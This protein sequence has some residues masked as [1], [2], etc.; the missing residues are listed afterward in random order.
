MLVIAELLGLPAEGRGLFQAWQ[1]SRT[2]A[3][4]VPND[5]QRTDSGTFGVDLDLGA[6]SPHIGRRRLQDVRIRSIRP[7]AGPK[8]TDRCCAPAFSQV[9]TVSVTA[10]RLTLNAHIVTTSMRAPFGSARMFSTRVGK[11]SRAE[12]TPTKSGRCAPRD[13]SGLNTPSENP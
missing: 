9:R 6:R 2:R 3:E 7:S 4:I 12:P 5:R 13:G 8:F 1:V 10:S 11:N